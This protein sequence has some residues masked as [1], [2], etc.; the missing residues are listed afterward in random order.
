LTWKNY[1]FIDLSGHVWDIGFLNTVIT[2]YSEYKLR[3]Q[4][5]DEEAKSLKILILGADGFIG[6]H[7]M[8]KIGMDSEN[9]T[10]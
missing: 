4:N 10:V 6:S 1:V 8:E 7:L 5:I 2:A 9:R 3:L